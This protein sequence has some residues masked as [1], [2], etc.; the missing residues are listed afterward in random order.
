[1]KQYL[2]AI[3]NTQTYQ[4]QAT[5]KDINDPA[6]YDFPGPVARRMYAEQV[7]DS[8]LVMTVSDIDQRS[9][10]GE[11]GRYRF[12]GKDIYEAYAKLK[13][14]PPEKLLELAKTMTSD[15]RGAR[16]QMMMEMM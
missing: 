6:Q 12:L 4:S 9:P 1:M 11:G 15:D 14:M 10:A 8:L 13:E 2:R 16:R 7:W 3:Y 5:A